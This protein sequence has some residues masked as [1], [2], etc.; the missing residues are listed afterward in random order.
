MVKSPPDKG[1][2]KD[3][4]TADWLPMVVGLKARRLMSSSELK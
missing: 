3:T 2:V 4:L 1:K